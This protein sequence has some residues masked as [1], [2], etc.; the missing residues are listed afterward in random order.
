MRFSAALFL[1]GISA[2]A[3]VPRLSFEQLV[4]TSDRV[5]EGRVVRT[6]V[7]WDRARQFIWTHYEVAVSDNVKGAASS[8]VVVSEPG[9]TLDGETMAI[10]GVVRYSRGDE[11]VLFLRRTPIGYLRTNGYEQGRYRVRDRAQ[12]ASLKA[13]VRSRV[14]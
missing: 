13:R 14:R 6:W 11:M 8:T 7:A 1:A 5:V 10:P 4:D 3:V 9:G 2:A 12:T